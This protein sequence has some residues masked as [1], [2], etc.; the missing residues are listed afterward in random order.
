MA[1]AYQAVGWNR[2]K[3]IYDATLLAGVGLFLALFCA[4][5]AWIE[6]DLTLETLWIRAL[7]AGAF[8]LLHVILSIG[9]LARLD[10]R[11]L[12]L[13]YNRRHMG[14]T[15]FALALAHGAFAL[16][17]YHALGVLSPLVSLF[18]GDVGGGGI[19]GV[20]F[21]PFGAVAL[22][23][24]FLMA[25]TSH[26]FWLANL[27][28]PAWKALH[29]LVY[30]AYALLVL[31]V[32][33]GVL[34]SDRSPW[35]AALVGVG[36]AWVLALHVFAAA[37]ERGVDRACRDAR[38]NDFVDV[39]GVDEIV[40][41][42]AKIVCA[43]GDRVAIFRYDGKLSAVSNACQHQN[44]PL[45]EGRIVDGCITCPW[46]GYQYLP[47]TGAS[48]PPFTERIPTF[49]VKVER[50]RVLLD[51]RPKPAGTRVEPARVDPASEPDD[52]ELYVG[53]LPASPPG[54]ARRTRAVVTGLVVAG[55]AASLIASSQ[56]RTLRASRF[57]HGVARSFRG[58]I[59]AGPYPM[60]AVPRPGRL[61]GAS[62]YL[63]VAPG[64]HGA[65]ELVA[66][67]DGREVTLAGSLVFHG[68]RTMIE[69]EPGS[70]AAVESDARAPALAAAESLGEVVLEGEIV[71][72][73]CHLGVMNPGE[74]RTHR[75]CAK[76]CIR[77]GIPPLLWVE[78]QSG[79]AEKLLLV[80]RD[81]RAV[82]DAVVDLV[83]DPVEVAGELVRDGD[84]LVLRADPAA[85]RRVER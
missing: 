12:P 35:L 46:H 79:H 2:Q 67:F 51:P 17:Q 80:D 10:R 74:R 4:I 36:L 31:H 43:A 70:I 75:A 34:Q 21:Q 53:Y 45:G 49:A 62:R 50:G 22:A 78:D 6:P 83:G 60:L 9:P 37:R 8:A 72:S 11:F 71:D 18:A 52:G 85:I 20:P 39:C 81:G 68:D 25:A 15:M 5:G 77:G 28:A 59:Q 47:E 61:D 73:K 54:L 23:I 30:A 3:R 84:W 64:K 29:M 26:D 76:L 33:F 65:R 48:P 13:L 42:R 16:V 63:L 69:V 44:G 58:W 55:I 27:T 1:H 40:E 14:V 66:D 57:E 7:G 32:A 41:K 38:S 82:N 56:V 24:L 19:A